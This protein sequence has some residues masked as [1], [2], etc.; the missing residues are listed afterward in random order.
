[1]K[2]S[3]FYL[4][5]AGVVGYMLYQQSQKKKAAAVAAAATAPAPVA[6]T[7]VAG[8]LGATMTGNA[9]LEELGSLGD[10]SP[11]WRSTRRY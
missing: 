9:M 3:T 4:I 5:G 10:G 2:T 8:A 11:A 6:P 1:M 7:T